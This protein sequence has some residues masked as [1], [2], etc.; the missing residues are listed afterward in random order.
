MKKLIF[1]IIIITFCTTVF[2]DTPYSIKKINQSG[3]HAKLVTTY[4]VFSGD[5]PLIKLANKEI[6]NTLKSH[7]DTNKTF[8]E[9]YG[10][11]DGYINT[12]YATIVRADK[13]IISVIWKGDWNAGGVHNDIIYTA[14]IGLVNGK[15]KKLT[16]NDIGNPKKFAEQIIKEYQKKSIRPQMLDDGELTAQSLLD[17]KGQTLLNSFTISKNYITF[18]R[19]EYEF[20]YGYEGADFVKIRFNY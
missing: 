4:P 17:E 20:G 16:I 2:A 7:I 18:Y 9:E 10:D 5:T 11:G 19:Q 8:I 15:A 1:I 12:A 6:L 13:K 3:K 14:T